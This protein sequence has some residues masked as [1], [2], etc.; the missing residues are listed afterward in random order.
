MLNER[1]QAVLQRDA[2]LHHQAGHL[3]F[4]GDVKGVCTAQHCHQLSRCG[5]GFTAVGELQ[6]GCHLGRG[7][8]EEFRPLVIGHADKDVHDD[9]RDVHVLHLGDAPHL[10]GI[11]F[12]CNVD[13]DQF[14][15]LG[16]LVL[17]EGTGFDGGTDLGV[18]V[19]P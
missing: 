8:G 12:P 4:L 3:G 6:P 18:D 2:G 15:A 5:N 16:Y 7:R 10:A 9:D 1:N 17:H 19:L 13:L 11:V 14:N